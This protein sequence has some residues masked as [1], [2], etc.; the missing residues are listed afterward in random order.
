MIKITTVATNPAVRISKM[1]MVDSTL[2]ISLVNMVSI[3]YVASML[4]E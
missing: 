1:P 2:V 4:M 3:L